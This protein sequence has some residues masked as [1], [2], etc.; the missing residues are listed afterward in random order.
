MMELVENEI[1]SDAFA[2]KNKLKWLSVM[3]FL[4]NIMFVIYLVHLIV[5]N[6]FYVFW[7][8]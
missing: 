7:L 5:S 1:N 4:N 6:V 3:H 8:V 2:D